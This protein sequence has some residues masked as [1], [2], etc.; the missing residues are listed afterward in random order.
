MDEIHKILLDEV[1]EVRRDLK[2]LRKDLNAFKV[3]MAGS[4]AAV[5]AA[6][7]AIKHYIGA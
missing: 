3:K 2:D 1:K 4:F 6:I 7:E 5:L